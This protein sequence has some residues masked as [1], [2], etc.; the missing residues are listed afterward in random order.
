[1]PKEVPDITRWVTP[2]SL[3]RELEIARR[4]KRWRMKEAQL[5]AERNRGVD[6]KGHNGVAAAANSSQAS[7]CDVVAS[8]GAP[9]AATADEDK[10]LQQLYHDPTMKSRQPKQVSLTMQPW[11][12]FLQASNSILYFFE[13]EE[14]KNTRG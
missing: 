8:D 12:S 2:G 3:F 14:L 11:A 7:F 10:T 5:R 6:T 1:M 9:I 13:F 4:K